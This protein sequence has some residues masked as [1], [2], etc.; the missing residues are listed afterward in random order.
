MLLEI[1]QGLPLHWYKEVLFILKDSLKNKFAELALRF[2]LGSE[3]RKRSKLKHLPL[4]FLS[5]IKVNEKY[6]KR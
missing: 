2:R 3:S 4:F 6:Y 5:G 1:R